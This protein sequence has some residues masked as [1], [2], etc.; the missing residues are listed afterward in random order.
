MK[1]NKIE[2]KDYTIPALIGVLV[3]VTI[4]MIVAL[5]ISKKEKE[6]QFQPP[7]MERAA[8]EGVPQVS[9]ELGYTELYREG[10]AYRV[11][12][13][14]VVT[15]EGKDAVVYFTNAESNE[16]YLKLRVLD[17][18]DQVLGETGLL[19]PGEYVRGVTLKEELAAGTKIKL[20]IMG[21]EPED[22][23]S[24]G[25]VLMNVAIGGVGE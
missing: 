14:G 20:K 7:A 6:A 22:Y 11:S 9:E 19:K 1:T 13:C 12:V 4:V 15:M 23:T 8:K 16:K 21:Y 25:S 3:V 10:M 5:S 2:K 24:A 18:N 17:E